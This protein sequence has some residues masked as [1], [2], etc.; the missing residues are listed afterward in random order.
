LSAFPRK[1]GVPSKLYHNLG[2]GKFVD[3][4]GDLGIKVEGEVRQI[5]WIDFDK[6]R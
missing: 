1:S 2:N 6:R 3:V 4:A 5:S